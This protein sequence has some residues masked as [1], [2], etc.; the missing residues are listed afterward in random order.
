MPLLSQINQGTDWV[1]SL[2]VYL[3]LAT[4]IG[5][6]ISIIITRLG[7]NLADQTLLTQKLDS[8][9]SSLDFRIQERTQQM[10][11]RLIQL[12]TAADISRTISALNDQEVLLG[13]VV[14]LLKDRFDLYYAGVFLINDN[15]Q[16]AILKAGTGEA[17]QEMI[18]DGHHLAVGGSSM[19]G[20]SVANRMARIALDVGTEAVRFNNPRLPL[21]RSEMALPIIAHDEV[22]GALTIQSE[23]P[24]AFDQDDI[25]ILEGV[26]GSLAI[27]LEN[28]RLYM[29]ARQNLDEI[30]ALNRDY[31]HHAWAETAQMNRD[32]TYEYESAF[33]PQGKST[34]TYQAPLALRGET[35]GEISLEMDQSELSEEDRS[36]IENIIT[37]TAVALENARLLQETERKAVQEQK[38]NQI[39]SRFSRAV[40]VDDISA[41]SCSRI[42]TTS[43]RS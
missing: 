15:R 43:H 33:H 11:H 22:F 34:H 39:S 19:I 2:V 30:R 23:K 6:S 31:L 9:R 38:L 13:Q 4:M 36:L 41:H 7:E 26:T 14:E 40:R 29:E 20:W 21:T 25:T 17:G 1:T 16:F 24:N 5:G 18:A 27:A 12:R 35:I 3:M 10:N 28:A 8:E 37:Q 32:L 42:G